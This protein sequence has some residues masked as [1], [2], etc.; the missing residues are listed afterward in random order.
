MRQRLSGGPLIV[1]SLALDYYQALRYPVPMRTIITLLA[2]LALAHAGELHE[3]A[4]ACDADRMRQLLSLAPSLSQT[5]EDGM[6]P[7][8]AAI[9]ARQR[10][11]VSLLLQAGADRNERDRKG[12]TAFEAARRIADMRD[13]TNILLLVLDA[14]K[15]ESEGPM[16]WSLESSVTQAPAGCDTECCSR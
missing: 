13:R 15:E 1:A 5:D 7:L 14:G 9:D 10:T 4:R 16:P 3:A 6:T 12:R 8:H 2:S 11:C